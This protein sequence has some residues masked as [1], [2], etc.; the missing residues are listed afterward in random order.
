MGATDDD[1]TAFKFPVDVYPDSFDDYNALT[2]AIRDAAYGFVLEMEAHVM[3]DDL[4]DVE[5][6]SAHLRSCHADAVEHVA[7]DVIVV[8]DN[9]AYASGIEALATN[10]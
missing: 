4:I 1:R 7:L 8:I 6:D 9:P 2:G 10:E 3:A 5:Y